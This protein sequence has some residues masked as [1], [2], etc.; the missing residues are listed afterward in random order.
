MRF[1]WQQTRPRI[2]QRYSPANPCQ[3]I[4]TRQP[5]RFAGTKVRCGFT[6]NK[7]RPRIRQRYSPAH[8]CQRIQTRQ[9]RRFAGK[10]RCGFTGNKPARVFAKGIHQRTRAR[11]YKRAN[12]AVLRVRSGAV[13][14]ATNP[15]AY[16]PKVFTSAPVPEDTNAPTAPFC[17]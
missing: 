6:G 8:P 9:P 3:R 17:G 11:G 14:L 12:R 1:H 15:P 10:V 2:R 16:S 5:R 13:S 4:Q 7:T